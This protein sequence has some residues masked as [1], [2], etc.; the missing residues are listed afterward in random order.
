MFPCNYFGA[1]CEGGDSGGGSGTIIVEGLDVEMEDT[2]FD[3]EIDDV[4]FDVE[5][6]DTGFDV[7]LDDDELEVEIS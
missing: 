4:F 7:E 2:C 6:N 1:T 3:V 5:I